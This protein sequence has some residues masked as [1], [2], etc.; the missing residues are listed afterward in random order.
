MEHWGAGPGDMGVW[1]CMPTA[2]IEAPH[3]PNPTSLVGSIQIVVDR[4]PL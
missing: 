1:P 4:E 3:S 2:H